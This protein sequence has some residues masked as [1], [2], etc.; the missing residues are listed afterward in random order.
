M[1]L[2]A[3]QS[4]AGVIHGGQAITPAAEWLIDNYYVVE[5]QIRDIRSDLPPSYY[6]ELP[7][8]VDGPLKG[9]P[10]VFG[11]AWAF[12]A[13]TD[14]RFDPELITRFVRAYQEVQP[15]TIGEL[16][17]VAITLRVVLV[18]NLRRIAERIVANR[19][20]RRDADAVADRLLGANGRPPEAVP[21]VM[22]VYANVTLGNAFS[23]QLV[24]RLRDQGPRIAPAIAWLDDMLAS[25][26]TTADAAVQ[27]EHQRQ[28]SATVTV[29]NI[30]TSMRLI[31]DVD[32]RTLFERMSLVDGVLGSCGLFTKMDFQ[33][34]NLYRSAI[35]QLA[36][37]SKISELEIAGRAVDAARDATAESDDRRGDPGYYLLAEG[38]RAFQEAIGFSPPLSHLAE[39]SSRALGISGYVAAGAT[40]AT[41]LLAIPFV[42]LSQSAVSGFAL[43]LLGLTGLVPAIDLAVA[44]VNRVITQ[45][46]GA[47]PLPSLAL[48]DGVT[49]E[50][51]TLVVMPTLLTSRAAIYEL[52]ER[53]EVHFLASPSGDL[54]FALL[55]DW[56]DAE[57]EKIDGDEELLI[58]AVDGIEKLNQRHGPVPAA[59]DRFLL[60]HRRRIWNAGE[61]KW[62][63]WERKRG[64]LHELNRLIRGATDTTF[65]VPFGGTKIP[66]AIRFVV[67]LDFRHSHSARHGAAAHRQDGASD[68]S[69]TI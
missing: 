15:L 67:T 48:L 61:G 40:V 59:G 65:I 5:R 37:G 63:G 32:W 39:R 26:G 69:S 8:L 19:L 11:I 27:N 31:S 36:R 28:T 9:Y 23:V 52:L 33:T 62:I 14:S 18:E 44:L 60:F 10:R 50:L 29:R 66:E 24:H 17:A 38:R 68:K 49:P 21:A 54:H 2:A 12:V 43:V 53:L 56:T 47:R 64:K 30:I 41:T 35:E 42:V 20:A 55:T 51:R 45:A 58:A 6:R 16:W 34:R 57:A 25:Q 3:Y 4:I 46:F 13:H 22:A 1:L 7:K